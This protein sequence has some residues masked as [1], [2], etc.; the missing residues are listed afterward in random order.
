VAEMEFRVG[1]LA[2][3]VSLLVRRNLDRHDSPSLSAARSGRL[4]VAGARDVIKI[5][6]ESVCDAASA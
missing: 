5:E 3:R 1:Q 4:V 2:G 6:A